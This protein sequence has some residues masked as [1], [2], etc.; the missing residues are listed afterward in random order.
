MDFEDKVK[1]VFDS[2]KQ[3]NGGYGQA[4]DADGGQFGRGVDELVKITA[5]FFS[6]GRDKVFQQNFLELF[7]DVGK[8]RKRRKYGQGYCQKRHQGDQGRI[9]QGRRN[10]ENCV[11]A[12]ALGKKYQ[13]IPAFGGGF[14]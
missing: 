11:I 3:Q 5:D 10:A 8:H 6:D 2:G 9:A 1:T 7:A 14:L 4:D 13:K 12:G